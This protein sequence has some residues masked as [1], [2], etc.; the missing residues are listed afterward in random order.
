MLGMTDEGRDPMTAL[1]MAGVAGV[2]GVAVGALTLAGYA[3]HIGGWE[4][5]MHTGA[6]ANV[7]AKALLIGAEIALMVAATIVAA[8]GA[9]MRN[10]SNA[11]VY[12][13]VGGV[14]KPLLSAALM[15]NYWKP[16]WYFILD[17]NGAHPLAIALVVVA[18]VQALAFWVAMAHR[19]QSDTQSKP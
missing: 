12:A 8:M 1:R 2:A 4:E 17:P 6:L 18:G 15:V 19:P 5:P 14:V 13:A 7:T 3:G 9:A 10:A 11:A 16:G